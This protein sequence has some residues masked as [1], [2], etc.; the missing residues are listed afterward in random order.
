MSGSP[1]KKCSCRTCSYVL[2]TN[3]GSCEMLRW[4]RHFRRKNKQLIKEGKEPL[5]KISVPYLA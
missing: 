3:R 5:E 4:Q 2:R 1:L